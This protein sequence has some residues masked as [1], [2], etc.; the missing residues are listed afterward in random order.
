MMGVGTVVVNP[1]L[2]W[3]NVDSATATIAAL[4]NFANLVFIVGKAMY[5]QTCLRLAHATSVRT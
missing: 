2:F 3:M 1:G 5:L 4:T